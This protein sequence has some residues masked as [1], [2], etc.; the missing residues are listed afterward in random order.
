M[1]NK[2]LVILLLIA[3]LSFA[4]TPQDSIVISGHLQGNTKF[5]KVL[6]KKYG[7]GSKDIAA[8]PIKDNVFSIAAPAET[9]AG[10]Y[11]LQYSQ[12]SLSEY[13]DIII[14]GREKNIVF[15][16]D[17]S[18]PIESRLPVFSNSE[19]N[20]K[21]YNYLKESQLPIQKINMLQ[22]LLVQYPTQKDKVL[23]SIKKTI[24][25]EKREYDKMFQKFCEANTNT[26]AG[27]MVQN[28]PYYFGN[29]NQEFKQ[30]E[31]ERQAQFWKGIDTT[32]PKLIN[33][34]IYTELILKY[35]QYYMNPQN[36]MTEEEVTKGF[37]ASVD[38][39]VNKFGGNETTKS[40]AISYLQL[41]FKEIGQEEILQYID[42]TYALN[43]QCEDDSIEKSE[44]EKRIAG[45]AALKKGNN[46]PNSTLHLTDNQ[47]KKL[48]A[49]K[50]NIIVLAFWASWCPNCEAQM[51]L[52]EAYAKNHKNISV[53]AISLDEDKIAYTKAIKKY[54]TM[55][56]SCDY[57]KW[58]S[59]A[60]KD[61]YI[62]GSPTFIVLDKNH[63]IIGKYSSWE[64]TKNVLHTD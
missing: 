21:W 59:A 17:V 42:E 22:Q 15:T 14:N 38:T 57:K 27:A 10:V 46:A 16:L 24:D 39:I 54:P 9:E 29:T 4:Q 26:W 23:K 32:D 8:I 12:S 3:T 56:H 1:K 19:E 41:G 33:T 20:Q 58:E 61:Y 62:Y 50:N 6:V 52:V 30:F 28:K 40:F 25:K 60:V 13:V 43:E 47:T 44:F 11:R 45:Y 48:H 37:M 36:P 18:Q 51:P 53:V 35:V 64:T 31:K 7:I 63:K 34:P 5:T 2:L 55:L 49:I